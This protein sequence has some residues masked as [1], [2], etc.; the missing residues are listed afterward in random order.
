MIPLNGEKPQMININFNIDIDYCVWILEFDGLLVSPFNH[1]PDGNSILRDRGLDES[2]WRSW[3]EKVVF[4]QDQRLNFQVKDIKQSAS[5]KINRFE[6]M[7]SEND[8]IKPHLQ[9]RKQLEKAIEYQLTWQEEQYQKASKLVEKKS[10]YREPANVWTEN[11]ATAQLLWQIWEIYR[12]KHAAKRR[13]FYVENGIKLSDSQTYMNDAQKLSKKLSS[14]FS[15]LDVLE[16]YLV[17]YPALI[18]YPVPPVS[19]ILSIKNGLPY[20]Y[21]FCESVER[22]ANKLVS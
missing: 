7:A 20:T 19:G 14:Y 2:S 10:I 15:H 6:R 9:D 17:D 11:S 16:I 13:K 18:E 4:T 1:H 12:S 8:N 22:I 5:E 21:S 3:L